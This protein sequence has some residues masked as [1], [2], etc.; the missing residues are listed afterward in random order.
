M[1]QLATLSPYSRIP[2]M[3]PAAPE[4]GFMTAA[5]WLVLA[6][7][8]RPQLAAQRRRVETGYHAGAS[9]PDRLAVVKSPFTAEAADDN[10]Q[11][12]P[13]LSS[14]ACL[15]DRGVGRQEYPVRPKIAMWSDYGSPT[16][17]RWRSR[18]RRGTRSWTGLKILLV[19]A[20]CVAGVIGISGIY[21]QIIDSQW[22]RGTSAHSQSVT[23][24]E[25]APETVGMMPAPQPRSPARP[26]WV[27]QLIGDSSEAA[28]LSRFRQMQGK[29]QSALGGFEP[30]ILRTTIKTSEAPVWVRVRIEF[31]TRQG[32]ESLCS[33]LEAAGETCLV[34]RNFER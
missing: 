25:T 26:G 5:R 15:V 11:S 24:S 10:V 20:A 31:D 34:Q 6:A 33:K 21:P 13:G 16:K 32:A 19:A 9:W 1:A 29:L 2:S 4:L 12:G 30:A 14:P 7:R 23:H 8:R 17:K 27:A 3:H 18:Y 22:A 28:A